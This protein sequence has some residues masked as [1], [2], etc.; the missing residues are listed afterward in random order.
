[1]ATLSVG[2]SLGGPPVDVCPVQAK[3]K[4]ALVGV[5]E[6][7]FAL[8]NRGE[9]DDTVSSIPMRMRYVTEIEGFV[10]SDMSTSKLFYDVRAGRLRRYMSETEAEGYRVIFKGGKAHYAVSMIPINLAGLVV[11]SNAYPICYVIAPDKKVYFFPDL[12]ELCHGSPVLGGHALG[13][14][15]VLGTPEG[16][17]T[18]ISNISGHYRPSMVVLRQ[19]VAILRDQGAEISDDAVIYHDKRKTGK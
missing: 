16:I 13:A 17:I 5:L 7:I 4:A 10:C 3:Q 2:L 8:R 9:R 14:G 6:Q 19:S 12:K 1:M 11:G 15:K 18:S